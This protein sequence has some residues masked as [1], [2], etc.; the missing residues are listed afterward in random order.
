[1]RILLF[2]FLL[3]SFSSSAVNVDFKLEGVPL[4]RAIAMIYDEVLHKPY[5]IDPSLTTDQSIISFHATE[6]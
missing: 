3:M 5:M 2:A 1:M 6:K 4:H